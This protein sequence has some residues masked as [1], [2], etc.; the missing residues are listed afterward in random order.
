L[1]KDGSRPTADVLDNPAWSALTTHQAHLAVGGDL[2][3]RYPSHITPIA[4]IGRRDLTSVEELARLIPDGDWLSL[5]ATLDQVAGLLPADVKVTLQKTL[6]QMVNEHHVEA[7]EPG[8]ELTVLSKA[9]IPEMMALT[10]L[11]HPG[12]FRTD[13]YTLGTYLGIRI[14]GRLGAMAGQRMH[15]PG[16]REISAVCTHPDLQGRGY[17]RMLVSQLV[18]DIHDEGLTPFLH[19]EETNQRAQ[20]IYAGLG[21]VERRRLPLLVIERAGP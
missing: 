12:P 3:K 17:A 1:T 10:E 21:F 2:A 7:P 14:D 18:A 15:L 13:T 8:L 4:A 11:T 19:L 9:D 20:A 6:V 5:P 16:Y